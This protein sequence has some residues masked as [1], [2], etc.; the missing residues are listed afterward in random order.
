[1]ETFP[2]YRLDMGIVVGKALFMELIRDRPKKLDDEVVLYQ[3]MD[4]FLTADR[5]SMLLFRGEMIGNKDE[6]ELLL[7]P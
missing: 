3:F 4:E 7:D 2:Y 1:M 6:I 5:I